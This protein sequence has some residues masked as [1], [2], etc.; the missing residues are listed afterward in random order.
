VSMVLGAPLLALSLPVE[1]LAS[2]ANR[3]AALT[4]AARRA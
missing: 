4:L 3:G 1:A 2:P